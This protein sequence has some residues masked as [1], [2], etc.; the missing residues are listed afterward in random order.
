MLSMGRQA[1]K[2]DKAMQRAQTA[3]LKAQN[4]KRL[5]PQ[6]V[7]LLPS[8][9]QLHLSG[10]RSDC[11]RGQGQFCGR[12]CRVRARQAKRAHPAQQSVQA[13]RDELD[14]SDMSSIC[15]QQKLRNFRQPSM[16]GRQGQR[17]MRPHR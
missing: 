15:F 9:L 11:R 14:N 8:S 1:Q 4:I 13:M 2:L 6:L 3:E 7:M 5:R 17:S 10:K 12:G 16:S